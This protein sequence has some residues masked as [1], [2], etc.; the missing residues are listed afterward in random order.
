V[1]EL[2]LTGWPP[3][4]IPGSQEPSA[5]R[6]H[7]D[8]GAALPPVDGITTWLDS[9]I[10]GPDTWRLHLRA[11]RGGDH[12]GGPG[13]VV[14]AE[15]DAGGTYHSEFDGGTGWADH[16]EFALRFLPRL[17]P[18]ARKLTLTVSGTSEEVTVELDLVS[19]A[20]FAVDGR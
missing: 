1:A 4:V 3:V 15:G 11:R 2:A 6:H 9:L 14:S 10:C 20:S 12:L 18:Q 8:I 19:A 7:L 16:E 5:S 13:L 17:D